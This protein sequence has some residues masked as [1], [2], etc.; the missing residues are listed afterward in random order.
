M[1]EALKCVAGDREDF[2]K[3][4]VTDQVMSW[5]VTHD[6]SPL[7]LPLLHN[8]LKLANRLAPLELASGDESLTSLAMYFCNWHMF[9]EHMNNIAC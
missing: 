6:D 1:S 7:S 3:A 4:C 9:R 5:Y 2:W 8:K